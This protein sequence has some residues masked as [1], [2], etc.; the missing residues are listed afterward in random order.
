MTYEQK[1]RWLGQY[2]AAVRKERLLESELEMMRSAAER[3]TACLGGTPGAGP[4]PDRLPRAVEK[5]DDTRKKLARQ[6]EECVACRVRVLRV[7]AGVEAPDVQEV[8]RRR[9]ILGQ[10]YP[11]IADAMNVVVRRVYQIHRAGVMAL[12]IGENPS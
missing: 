9:Y 2:G 12:D 1:I 7:V 3:V 5:I 11:E 10:T 6:V 8:L 4:D